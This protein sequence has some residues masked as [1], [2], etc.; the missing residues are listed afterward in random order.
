[1]PTA[2][3]RTQE[4]KEAL[5]GSCMEAMELRSDCHFRNRRYGAKVALAALCC[6]SPAFSARASYQD[7]R[8]IG[9]QAGLVKESCPLFFS[10]SGG[11]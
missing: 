1:M 9:K 5:S 8:Q 2:E 6:H 11:T 7:N 10:K 3:P 4:E